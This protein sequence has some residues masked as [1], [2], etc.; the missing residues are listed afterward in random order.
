MLH[1]SLQ[2]KGKEPL[3]KDADAPVEDR[4]ADLVQR[5][6]LEEKVMQM[7]QWTYGK[8]ANPNNIE[9]KMR[10]VQPEIGSLIFRSTEPEYRN[11]I[12]RKAM[13]ESRLGIPI[14]FGFDVIHGYRTVFPI[15]LAQACSW[16]TD[17][18]QKSCEVAAKEAWLSGVDW[19]FSPMIDVARDPRWGRVSEAYGEDT[20]ANSA[21]AV[22]AVKGY[23][24][25]TLSDKYTIAACLKHFVGYSYSEGGRDY[26]YSDIS[27]QTMWETLLPPFE[28]GVAAGAAT[29]MSGFNDI[30]GVP[31]T[32]NHYTLTEILKDKWGHDG[33]VVSDW[34]S[35]KNLINQGV[36]ASRKEAAYQAFSAGTEMDMVDNVY[37][38]NL[39]QLVKEGRIDR[40]Q[41]DDAVSRILRVKMRLGL[42]EQPYV[43]VVPV[44]QRYFQSLPVAEQLAEESMV[45]LKNENEV[46]P[47][48]ASTPKIALIG[49]MVKDSVHIM[50]FWEGMGR[51]EDVTSIYEGISNE[52]KDKWTINYAQ[53]CDFDGGDTSL[54]AKAR[55]QAQAS[56]IVVL[57]LG[58]KRRWSGENG[59]RSTIAL[60]SIQEQLFAELTAIGKP[61]VLVLSSGRPL[62]IKDMADQADAILEIWQPGSV[63]AK[64]LAGIL[65]GR[66]NPSGKLSITFPQATGQIPIYYNQR[67]VANPNMGHYQDIPKEPLYEFG[68]GLSYTHFEYSD[69]VL[70]KD[71]LKSSETLVATIEV[72]N[73]GDF[74]GKETVLWYISDPVA[75]ISRP[76][77]ALKYFEKQMINRE[78]TVSYQFE[79]DPQRD[80]SFVDS[81][82]QR[83][84]EAGLF[85]LHVNGQEVPFYLGD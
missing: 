27:A 21:F 36:A 81:R 47:L 83:H 58:E 68:A 30:S 75:S 69:V 71:T 17:L 5:M 41:I 33:F 2:A 74:D 80:L 72:T 1:L 78:Q 52:F 42:F 53:G 16:N 9:D 10:D 40:T 66:L 54:L 39:P 82:G 8:N 55:F 51:A 38:E 37:V 61:V 62:A 56:D 50:G 32:S 44:D 59:S 13:E 57:C 26:H 84:L 24:G 49:P 76:V 60:P 11:D 29:V 46:L 70:S 14:I 79:I 19:T 34:G 67:P 6:T 35:V 31:A 25:D 3:Y 28:A 73:R 15:P 85:Y 22:A 48:N 65:S 7:N 20:Y 12:Q 18:V 63:G 23:Q 77:R 4:I 64:A 45:L 43:D